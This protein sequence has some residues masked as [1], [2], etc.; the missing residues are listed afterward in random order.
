MAS[1]TIDVNNVIL[2]TILALLPATFNAQY[3]RIKVTSVNRITGCSNGIHCNNQLG[4]V[5]ISKK[6]QAK[7]QIYEISYGINLAVSIVLSPTTQYNDI[8]MF[9]HPA[10]NNDNFSYVSNGN[11]K[12]YDFHSNSVYA[13]NYLHDPSRNETIRYSGCQTFNHFSNKRLL[14]TFKKRLPVRICL[15]KGND[16]AIMY[17]I[18]YYVISRVI[19]SRIRQ[20][21]FFFLRSY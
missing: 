10:F 2:P 15:F 1:I 17:I 18:G 4:I 9:K 21:Y 7:F 5:S 11:F 20:K 3:D 13:H 6:N 19:T 8:D 16:K 14:T 12:F